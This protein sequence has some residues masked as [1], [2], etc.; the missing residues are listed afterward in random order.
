V[1]VMLCWMHHPDCDK[2]LLPIKLLLL[3]LM[4]P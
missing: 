3:L 4:A 1:L 2:S